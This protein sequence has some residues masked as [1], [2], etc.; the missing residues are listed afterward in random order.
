MDI[1]VEASMILSHLVM[2]REGHLQE[3]FHVFGYL[4]KHM[5]SEMV[6]DPSEPDIDMNSFPKQDWSY[7]IYSSPGEEVKEVLPP[8]MP[9]P[10][11]L[12][13]IIHV[14][15]DANHAG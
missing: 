14:F 15:V 9:T 3:L 2:P 8:N 11:G 4:H 5:N 7:S 10:L 12:G 6:F 1:N 13:F